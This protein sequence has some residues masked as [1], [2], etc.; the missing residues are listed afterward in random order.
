[1]PGAAADPPGLCQ[2]V[3]APGHLPRAWSAARPLAPQP[4]Q[5]P[6]A[7]VS[8]RL[9]FAP[10]RTGTRGRCGPGS[11]GGSPREPRPGRHPGPLAGPGPG[12]QLNSSRWPH[13]NC[14][15]LERP[16]PARHPSL[17]PYPQR[18]RTRAHRQAARDR[19]IAHACHAP[20]QQARAHTHTQ[21]LST[22]THRV[23]L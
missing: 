23:M 10:R 4:G 18:T 17:R 7:A 20:A 19:E 6:G 22:L 5:E 14:P 2:W 16:R 13:P 11:H 21:W 1:M 3:R 12:R 8:A 9:G 15:L